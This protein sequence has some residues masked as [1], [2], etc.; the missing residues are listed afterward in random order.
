MRYP[1]LH[2]CVSD[3]RFSTFLPSTLACACVSLASWKLDLVDRDAVYQSVVVVLAQLLSAHA[4]SPVG[5]AE[6]RSG[7]PLRPVSVSQQSSILLCYDLLGSLLE[8]KMP[9]FLRER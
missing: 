4:V 2:S 9:W 1:G 5:R 8:E 6:G 3:C 7:Q